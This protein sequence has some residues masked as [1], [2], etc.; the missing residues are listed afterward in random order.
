LLKIVLRDGGQAVQRS[1]A[2]LEGGT[3][4]GW[5]ARRRRFGVGRYLYGSWFVTLGS[6]FRTSFVLIASA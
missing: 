3:N 2:H 5:L 4:I 6:G 1:I